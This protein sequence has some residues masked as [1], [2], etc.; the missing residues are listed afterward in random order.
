[1]VTNDA[2]GAAKPCRAHHLESLLLDDGIRGEDY[3]WYNIARNLCEARNAHS[4]AASP[5]AEGIDRSERQ[6]KR[7]DIRMTERFLSEKR[8]GEVGHDPVLG[9]RF[10]SE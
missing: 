2:P 4:S 8:K 5:F 6:R 7:M 1:M 10:V 9:V 3:F